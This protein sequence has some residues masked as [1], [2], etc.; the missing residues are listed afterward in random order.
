M[1][2]SGFRGV[3][4]TDFWPTGLPREKLRIYKRLLD[5][6]QISRPLVTY[7]ATTGSVIVEYWSAIPHDW[8][9]DMAKKMLKEV[10]AGD[11]LP[12]HHS[13]DGDGAGA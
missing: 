11:H 8:L 2:T 13:P 6:K 3:A 10:E 5:S 1:N 12:G 4:C 7:N 9:L